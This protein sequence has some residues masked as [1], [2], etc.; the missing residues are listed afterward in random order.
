MLINIVLLGRRVQS[1]AKIVYP[2]SDMNIV[3]IPYTSDIKRSGVVNLCLIQP[4][5][6]DLTS[7]Y[8]TFRDIQTNRTVTTSTAN[9]VLSR[10]ETGMTV[11]LGAQRVQEGLVYFV[12]VTNNRR[13]EFRTMAALS[14]SVGEGIFTCSVNKRNEVS[15]RLNLT[16]LGT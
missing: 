5:L 8:A 15:F 2:P 14:A 16:V 13:D 11:T 3:Q 7:S 10:K 4:Y 9:V 1:R 6:S 12:K